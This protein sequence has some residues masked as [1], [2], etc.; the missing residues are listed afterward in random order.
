MSIN[1]LEIGYGANP[2]VEDGT[3]FENPDVFY[4]GIELPRSFKGS[5]VLPRHNYDFPQATA[6]MDAMPFPDE[7]FDYVLMRSVYGQ[8]SSRPSIVSAVRMGVYECLRVLKPEGRIVVSEENTPNSMK[9]IVGE[10]SHAGFV[11]EAAQHM[12]PTPWKETTE[13]DEYRKLRSPFYRDE[14]IGRFGS[15]LGTPHIVIGK[16]PADIELKEVKVP[17]TVNFYESVKDPNHWRDKE[18]TFKVPIVK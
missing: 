3:L 15:I 5:F 8:F 4:T 6:S 16:K 10:I 7:R 18:L 14:P 1:V 13:E 12:S 11:I 17:C 2:A 9:Y